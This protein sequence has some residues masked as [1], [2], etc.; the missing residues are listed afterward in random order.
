MTDTHRRLSLTHLQVGQRNH[1]KRNLQK[2]F[3]I[4]IELTNFDRRVFKCRSVLATFR[5]FEVFV[6]KLDVVSPRKETKRLK[7]LQLSGLSPRSSVSHWHH[8][9]TV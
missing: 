9:S 2:I 1:P 4:I 6:R 5:R 7:R 8:S 3:D